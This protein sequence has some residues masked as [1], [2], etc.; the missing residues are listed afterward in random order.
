MGLL[1]IC[2]YNWRL[3][4]IVK[5][6]LQRAGETSEGYRPPIKLIQIVCWWVTYSPGEAVGV[7]HL[8]LSQAVTDCHSTVADPRL[9]EQNLIDW[10]QEF[11]E[12][13]CAIDPVH[14]LD[15]WMLYRPTSSVALDRYSCVSTAPRQ[16]SERLEAQKW[17]T[18]D[19]VHKYPPYSYNRTRLPFHPAFN[20]ASFW[21]REHD[22]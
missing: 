7:S 18:D 3:Y 17:L 11:V 10:D 9:A 21:M 5:W 2:T 6:G 19:Y 14:D 12:R 20:P 1:N 16:T 8:I 22:L 15:C 13:W 4:D